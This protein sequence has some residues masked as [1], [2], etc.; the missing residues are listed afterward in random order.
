MSSRIS[1]SLISP[2]V[3]EHYF[4]YNQ[5]PALMRFLANR[6]MK[7]DY[8]ADSSTARVARRTL[9]VL[10]VGIAAAAQGGMV[11]PNMKAAN[12][13]KGLGGTLVVSNLSTFGSFYAYCS[14]MILNDAF[15]TL[16]PEEKELFKSEIPPFVRNV[17]KGVAAMAGALSQ[18]PMAYSAYKANNS[19][20]FAIARFLDAGLPIRSL[21]LGVKNAFSNLNLNEVEKKLE[22][23]RNNLI[24]L[25][26]QAQSTLLLQTTESRKMLENLPDLHAGSAEDYL[27]AILN[28]PA[29][30]PKE[31]EATKL[32]KD[33]LW[34]ISHLSNFCVMAL[35][36]I[37]TYYAMSLITEDET[38]K[39]LAALFVIA[40]KFY[41]WKD[42]VSRAARQIPSDIA[43]L[44]MNNP[45]PTISQI[46]FPKTDAIAT[47]V[48]YVIGGFSY[49]SMKYFCDLYGLGDGGTAATSIATALLAK[50]T[51]TALKDGFAEERVSRRGTSE[52][53]ALLKFYREL[54]KIVSTVE[55]TCRKEWAKFLQAL[56]EELQNKLSKNELGANEI[57]Q[58]LQLK[59]LGG[60]PS[61]I[62]SQELQVDLTAPL[63]FQSRLNS[64]NKDIY[65]G[66]VDE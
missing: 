1:N 27:K 61:S 65:N 3:E 22:R 33:V 64:N 26:R 53:Q 40:C 44:S 41:L 62:E 24:L 50:N 2:Q 7:N 28:L 18:I 48:S 57:S 9:Q 38:L 8:P 35:Y 19:L 30:T 59:E 16:S 13:N 49:G 39:I 56:P 63:I 46:C 42:S 45:Q 17:F 47:G 10:A 6:L 14:W 36:G 34:G 60:I 12:G 55:N 11:D 52:Q 32:T 21:Y 25:L 29:P 43:R 37:I 58:Y 20:F 31:S 4:R 66:E 51:F 23:S 15:K 5:E 54:G